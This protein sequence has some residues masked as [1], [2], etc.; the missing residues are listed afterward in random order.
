M[1]VVLD[2]QNRSSFG[3]LQAAL[4]RRQA[5]RSVFVAFDVLHLDGLDRR[6]PLVVRRERLAGLVAEAGPQ[7]QFSE[8]SGTPQEVFD[9]AD[10]AGLEGVVCKLADS[11]Y[12]SGR[13]KQW[14]KAKT[15]R[16]PT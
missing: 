3:E 12:R 9:V 6:L 1:V 16:K 4:G 2:E 14:L 8:A 15:L 5:S 7:I 13:A 11:P 10:R